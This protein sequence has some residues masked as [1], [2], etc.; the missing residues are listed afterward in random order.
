MLGFYENAR[1]AEVSRGNKTMPP[2]WRAPNQAVSALYSFRR[3]FVHHLAGT[4]PP[5][6]TLVFVSYEYESMHV[7]DPDYT[8]VRG[9]L[10]GGV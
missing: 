4:A 2:H 6:A 9:R 10:I 1:E 5:D 7:A 8:L 3:K